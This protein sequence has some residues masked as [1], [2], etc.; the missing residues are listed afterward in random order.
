VH[1]ANGLDF[2]DALAAGPVAGNSDT[3]IQLSG[4]PTSLGAGIP[5]FLGTQVVGAGGVSTLNALGLTG[6]VSPAVM[7]AAAASI[8]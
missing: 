7:S 5:T 1:I 2:P 6:A 8:G 4:S 3:V